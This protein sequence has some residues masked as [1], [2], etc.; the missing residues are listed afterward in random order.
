MLL[1]IA[2]FI[3]RWQLDS[4]A[5][6]ENGQMKCASYSAEKVTMPDLK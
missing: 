5:I 3:K 4:G 2:Q 1:P 6:F